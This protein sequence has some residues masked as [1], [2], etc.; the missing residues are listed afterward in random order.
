MNDD[1]SKR[2][3]ALAK[4]FEE[5]SSSN[6][7]GYEVASNIRALLVPREVAPWAAE[8]ERKLKGDPVYE[9]EK[10]SLAAPREEE[11][12]LREAVQY[13]LDVFAQYDGKHIMQALQ[14]T[15]HIKKMAAALAALPVEGEK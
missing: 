2:V 9:A 11:P 14:F 15:D 3:E 5:N 8:V 10:A 12:G 6:W 1:L 7:L 13:A 4:E